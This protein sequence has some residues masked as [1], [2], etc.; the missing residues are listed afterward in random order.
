MYP[1]YGRPS[2]AS[3]LKEGDEGPADIVVTFPDGE[4]AMSEVGSKTT[5]FSGCA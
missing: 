4:R 1:E 2:D 5:V 3:P